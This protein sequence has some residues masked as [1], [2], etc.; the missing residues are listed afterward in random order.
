[1]A[2]GVSDLKLNYVLPVSWHTSSQAKSRLC[3]RW[4][5]WV[6]R[7]LPRIVII[8][9]H[10]NNLKRGM[11]NTSGSPSLIGD[12]NIRNGF[13]DTNIHEYHILTEVKDR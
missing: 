7:T 3:K 13:G 5:M 6:T 1:M 12:L 8:P 10:P 2:D 11:L 9:E 4:R